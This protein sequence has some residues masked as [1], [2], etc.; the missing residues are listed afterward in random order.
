MREVK[1]TNKILNKNIT[2]KWL[3]FFL[4]RKRN[5]SLESLNLI[6]YFQPH[7]THIQNVML[8]FLGPVIYNL[9]DALH[10]LYM[11]FTN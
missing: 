9:I 8:N 11:D 5:Y 2:S 1:S 3:K 7:N 10:A 4:N 6:P